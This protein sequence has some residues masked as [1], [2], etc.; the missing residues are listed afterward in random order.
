[1]RFSRLPALAVC[2]GLLGA[3]DAAQA[4]PH[5]FIDNVATF[6]FDQRGVAAIRLRWTFDEIFSASIISQFDRNK[7]KSF[8][9][10]ELKAL[11]AGAFDNL[12]NFGYFSHIDVDDKP[13]PTKR[14]TGFK[15]EIVKDQLVYEF[16]VPL[17]AAVDPRRQ[18]LVV[19]I[20]D[21]EYFVDIDVAGKDAVRFEGNAG[22]SCTAPVL[23]NPRKP[24]Y[25]GMVFPV[26]L[27]LT[28]KGAP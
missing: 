25:G 13:V 4:H 19:G 10:E 26:E 1:M 18:H 28:C 7:D 20:Y 12:Q 6:V 9:A 2:L 15:A 5:V 8:D 23:E 11:K 21:P 14:V 24:I 17:D 16:T 3:P 22:I 27:H